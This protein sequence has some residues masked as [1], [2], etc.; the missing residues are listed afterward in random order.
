MKRLS[1]QGRVLLASLSGLVP[2]LTAHYLL[3]LAGL[4]AGVS[5]PA[6]LILGMFATLL[7]VLFYT[8]QPHM[9]IKAIESGLL[10]L[11]DNDYSASI[12]PGRADELSVAVGLYNQVVDKLRSE[13][14]TL[15]Q[16]ELLLDTVIQNSN[17]ALLLTDSQQRIIYANR[18]ASDFFADGKSLQGA[19]MQ[20]LLQNFP[21]AL[22]D[23]LA[24]GKQGLFSVSENNYTEV[25][26]LSTG[27]FVLQNQELTLYLFKKMTRDINQK[28]IETW[29]KVIRVISHE[30]NNSLAPISSMANSGRI[31]LEKNQTEKLSLVFDTITERSDHLKYFIQDY[32]RLARLPKPKIDRV[33]WHSFISRLEQHF[34]FVLKGEL[35]EAEAFFDIAQLEQ[36]LINLLKNAHESGSATDDICLGIEQNEQVV[37]VVA[38]RGNGANKTIME[39]MLL[40]FYTTKSNGSGVGLPLCREIVEAHG[41]KI[42]VSPRQAKGL[43]VQIVLPILKLQDME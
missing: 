34:S 11:L 35:P 9:R 40:P 20:Q 2:A 39:N 36:A 1:L 32:I 3:L 23:M 16:R 21:S 6:S 42:S 17:L 31:M 7:S 13:R 25:Y 37:I 14:Q 27:K 19:M 30:L 18:Q 33:N 5:L 8:R 29:K 12:A 43:E 38:D 28:E 15:Y 4:P 22:A 10:N 26:H 41:G 24:N